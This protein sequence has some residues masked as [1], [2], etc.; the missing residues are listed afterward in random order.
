MNFSVKLQ[1]LRKERNLSQEEF[2]EIMNVSRQAVSKWESGQSLPEIDKLI[3]I[4]NYFVVS[5]DNLIK[6]EKTIID[7]E[8]AEKK[9]VR[10][11]NNILES[12][13]KRIILISLV[14]ACIGICLF[15]LT[16]IDQS[17][18]IYQAIV[19]IVECVVGISASLFLGFKIRKYVHTSR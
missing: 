8:L 13:K 6:N 16:T 18:N 1:N 17:P 11:S 7:K 3:E 4:S 15:G 2:A 19:R 12:R 10:K 14:T 9:E 5:I